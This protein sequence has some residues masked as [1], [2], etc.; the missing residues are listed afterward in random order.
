MKIF[1]KIDPHLGETEITV[2]TWSEEEYKKVFQVFDNRIKLE[3]KDGLRIVKR[4]ELIY[5][6]ALRNYLDLHTEKETLTVRL[7][8]YKLKRLLG[9]DFIQVS[10]S[11]LINFQLLTS[12]EA[13]VFNGMIARVSGL[14][15]PVSQGYLKEIYKRMEEEL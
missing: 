2:K 5:V 8:L 15:V 4:S 1:K 13:D 7:P 3:T 10:R 12:V 9:S 11:Y 6:E 14:K